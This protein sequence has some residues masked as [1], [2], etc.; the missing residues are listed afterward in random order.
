MKF[1]EPIFLAAI[2]TLTASTAAYSTNE[3]IQLNFY[4]DSQC[5]KYIGESDHAWPYF[6]A[7]PSFPED[8]C[9]KFSQPS[10]TAS[11]NLAGAYF[12]DSS[13]PVPAYCTLYTGFSC[14]GGEQATTVYYQSGQGC[15]PTR[16]PTGNYL[17]K[18]ARCHFGAA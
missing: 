18:S 16:S 6:D 2:A 15:V 13:T 9:F 10:G 4:S 17:W 11:L 5:T 7:D 12:Y 14:D 8:T 1:S 3:A